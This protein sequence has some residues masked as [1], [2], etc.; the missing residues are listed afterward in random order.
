MSLLARNNFGW[1]LVG[2]GGGFPEGGNRA[3]LSF[4]FRFLRLRL[5]VLLFLFCLGR[6][7]EEWFVWGISGFES[8]SAR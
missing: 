4:R 5:R 8:L 1:N 3:S 7:V 2:V 6:D